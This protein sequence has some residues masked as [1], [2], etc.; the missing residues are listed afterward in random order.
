MVSGKAFIPHSCI[1]SEKDAVPLSRVVSG[2]QGG[3]SFLVA[4][5]T[6]FQNFSFAAMFKKTTTIRFF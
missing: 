2:K 1:N 3:I 4:S 5:D 6:G